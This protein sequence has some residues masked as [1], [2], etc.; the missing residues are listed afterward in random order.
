VERFHGE[1]ERAWLLRKGIQ[2]Q[3]Q[4]W[5]DGYRW[6]HNDVRPHAALEMKTPLS[7]WKRSVRSYDSHSGLELSLRL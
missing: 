6:E 3:P 2:Q 4:L 7:V 1:L 5:L